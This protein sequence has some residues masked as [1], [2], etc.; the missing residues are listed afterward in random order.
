MSQVTII[1]EGDPVEC[2]DMTGNTMAVVTT[3]I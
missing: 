1:E 3:R 2:F